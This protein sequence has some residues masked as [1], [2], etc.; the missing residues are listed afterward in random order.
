MP[1]FRCGGGTDTSGLYKVY[2]GTCGLTGATQTVRCA[3][4]G[5]PDITLG[6]TILIPGVSMINNTK[7][8]GYWLLELK[9]SIHNATQPYNYNYKSIIT[10]LSVVM[11]YTS[12]SLHIINEFK[13]TGST[14]YNSYDGHAKYGALTAPYGDNM[15]VQVSNKIGT[16]T[17][18]GDITDAVMLWTPNYPIRYRII[19]YEPKKDLFG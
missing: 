12:N 15:I 7:D 1:Y 13:F 11:G 5:Y 18:Y 17:G 9:N 4:T 14:V 10:H 19:P 2:E 3:N 8:Y 16:T 6:G